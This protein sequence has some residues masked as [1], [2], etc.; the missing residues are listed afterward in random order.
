MYA[1][2]WLSVYTL[3]VCAYRVEIVA[4]CFAGVLP[5]AFTL[6]LLAESE[7]DEPVTVL[8]L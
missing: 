3:S 8:A 1:S 5:R 4:S 6:V 7:D 2:V